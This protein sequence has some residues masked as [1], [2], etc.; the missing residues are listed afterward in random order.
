MNI[1][2]CLKRGGVAFYIQAQLQFKIRYDLSIKECESLFIE[3]DNLKEKNTI[4]GLIYR[5]PN[6]NIDSF[7]EDFARL[8]NTISREN[9]RLYFMGDFNIDLLSHN[10][11][12]ENF[13]QLFYSNACYPHID[14]PTRIESNS[15]TLIDNIFSNIYDADITSGLLSSEISD[16]LPIF[17]ICNKDIL[18]DKQDESNTFQKETPQNIPSFKN[19]LATED[20]TDVYSQRNTDTA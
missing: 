5:L 9:K 14:K 3:I 19:D 15:S 16:H 10:N 20:W 18:K 11:N 8:F 1:N 17:V 7:Y 12:Q 6:S 4:I 2:L 13:L